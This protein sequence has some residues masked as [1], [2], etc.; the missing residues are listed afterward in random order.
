MAAEHYSSK[1]QLNL[2]ARKG[3]KYS[4]FNKFLLNHENMSLIL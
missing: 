1:P 4:A 2:E 3:D